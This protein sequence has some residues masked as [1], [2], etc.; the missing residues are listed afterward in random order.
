MGQDLALRR[1]WLF[2]DC[3]FVVLGG[4]N[5]DVA[6][7]GFATGEPVLYGG[8]EMEAGVIKVSPLFRCLHR[9]VHWLI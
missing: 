1:C 2:R 6:S 7:V 9:S 8:G 3:L 5:V 4:G